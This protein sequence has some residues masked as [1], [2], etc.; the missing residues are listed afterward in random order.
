MCNSSNQLWT[1]MFPHKDHI[2]KS[3]L[4][5]RSSGECMR[6]KWDATSGPLYL[7]LY[8]YLEWTKKKWGGLSVRRRW[9]EGRPRGLGG[10]LAHLDTS[11]T[12]KQNP[13]MQPSPPRRADNMQYR[14][15]RFIQT[16][17][18]ALMCV[19]N[20]TAEHTLHSQTS[21]SVQFAMPF[22]ASNYPEDEYKDGRVQ[23]SISAWRIQPTLYLYGVQ[24]TLHI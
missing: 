4:G 9:N 1:E 6:V 16:P 19:F 15:S 20:Q 2:W 13:A 12:S 18:A 22:K 24:Y 21:Q 5:M 17:C 8:L 7:Y 10:Q 3:E 11:C 23:P 14:V